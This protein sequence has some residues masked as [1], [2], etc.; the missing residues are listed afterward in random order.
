M[1][2]STGNDVN[3]GFAGYKME[4][5]SIPASSARLAIQLGSAAWLSIRNQFIYYLVP[6]I[7]NR[8]VYH[9]QILFRDPEVIVRIR[10]SQ[11]VFFDLA[12]Y[13]F[14]FLTHR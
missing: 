6:L 5:I 8:S 1:E 14:D 12:K 3:T 13:C 11:F 9:I 2:S 4:K 10:D 7:Q